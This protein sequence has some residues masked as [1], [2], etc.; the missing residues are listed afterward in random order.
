MR[1]EFAAGLHVGRRTVIDESGVASALT[2]AT[3]RLIGVAKRDGRPETVGQAALFLTEICNRL[4]GFAWLCGSDTGLEWLGVVI[5]EMVGYLKRDDYGGATA[6]LT[7][8]I[9]ARG[10]AEYRLRRIERAARELVAADDEAASAADGNAIT[11]A[12]A[13][14]RCES[15]WAR[16][17]EALGPDMV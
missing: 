5:Q 8:R 13:D 10:G 15:A 3:A 12:A 4:D 9:V 16:L 11:A 14:R 17:C 2:S 6:A 7:R 1:D